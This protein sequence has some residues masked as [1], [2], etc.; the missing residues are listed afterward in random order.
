MFSKNTMSEWVAVASDETDEPVEV[1]AES[2]GK[3]QQK[4]KVSPSKK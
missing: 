3:S 4:V 2:D 1:P